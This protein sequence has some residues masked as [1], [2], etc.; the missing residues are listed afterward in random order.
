M[1]SSDQS[2]FGPYL[3]PESNLQQFP[4]NRVV[5]DLGCGGGEHLARLK[6]EG[7]RAV[8]VEL[9]KDLARE[10]RRSGHLVIVA[11]GEALPVRSGSCG[12]VLCK[13]VMPYTEERKV[14][15]EIARIL[16]PGGVAILILHGLGY[17]LLYLFRPDEWRHAVYAARTIMNT[18]V[19]R[20]SGRRLPGFVGDTI[21]Q[22]PV[23]MRRY[24][25]EEGLALSAETLSR[26]FLGHPVF[27]EQVIRR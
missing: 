4:P 24:Y 10:C 14:V 17:S 21:Y 12:G 9:S 25:G 19:Y 22:S 6:R 23:R 3:T 15:H 2:Y 16:E 1:R 7:R 5:L 18:L 11:R 20:W 13:V 26:P 27:F 8:G